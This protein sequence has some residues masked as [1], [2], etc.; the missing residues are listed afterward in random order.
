MTFVPSTASTSGAVA[1]SAAAKHQ[2]DLQAEEELMTKYGSDEIE[3]WE[4]KIVR[5]S[6]R[7]F[8]NREFLRATC[9]EEARAGW[10]MLE[11]F[12]D[13]RVRL[14]RKIEHRDGDLHREIDPYRTL[15]GISMDHLGFLIAASV[16]AGTGILLGIVF[17]LTA[18]R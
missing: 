12:D 4:F 7:K 9:E 16:L 3:D 5:A 18:L 1:A 10:E 8:K 15:V 2:Q 14:R 13:N 11:K 6:T 17:W